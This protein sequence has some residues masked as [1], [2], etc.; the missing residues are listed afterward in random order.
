MK[1]FR[2]V[3]VG[4]ALAAAF[5]LACLLEAPSAFGQAKG[6]AIEG[7]GTGTIK[8]KV[9]LDGKAPADAKI[10]IDPNHK[11][12]SHCMKGDTDDRTWVVGADNGLGNVVVF[13]KPP[14]G[15]HFK[16]DLGKKTWKD[17]VDIDQ[18]FCNFDPHVSVIFPDYEGKPTGQ[19]FIVK[20]S[21]PITH[22][23]RIKGGPIRNPEKN[24]TLE[25]HKDRP[26]DLKPD[27][28]VIKVNCDVHKW[29][30]GYIWAFDHPYAAITDKDGNFEI[31]DVPTGVDLTV[32]AW[33]E[34]GTPNA[35]EVKKGPLTD[36]QKFDIKIKKK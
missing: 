32:M 27:V 26:V 15:A 33:H 25:S 3:A 4:A 36:G 13:L 8:G 10:K 28:E 30:Q 1:R 21:A 20:N 6:K 29:M 11:D 35:V 19:K 2:T 34:V 24:I 22:N 17:E 12:A 7:K 9:T 23:T 5:G 16:V 14:A 31:K 18:P